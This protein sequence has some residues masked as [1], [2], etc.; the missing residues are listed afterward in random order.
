MKK[1]KKIIKFLSLIESYRIKC[2]IHQG[3]GKI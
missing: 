2:M 1:M 3:W